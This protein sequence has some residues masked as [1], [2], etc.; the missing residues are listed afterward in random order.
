MKIKALSVTL[1]ICMLAGSQVALAANDYNTALNR[2]AQ[3]AVRDILGK[4]IEK[5]SKG[6]SWSYL[7]RNMAPKLIDSQCGY[8]NLVGINEVGFAGARIEIEA[9]AGRRLDSMFKDLLSRPSAQLELKDT[10]TVKT[11]E[12]DRSLVS[13]KVTP[14]KPND[15]SITFVMELSDNGEMRLCDIAADGKIEEGVLY[16]LGNEL[17]L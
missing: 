7:L 9:I 10:R 8:R 16:K 12:A 1:A 3:A 11:S 6:D 17:N 15:K 13:L 4:M 14:S 5:R 2:H